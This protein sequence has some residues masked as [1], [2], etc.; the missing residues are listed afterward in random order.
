MQVRLQAHRGTGA[1]SNDPVD[2]CWVERSAPVRGPLSLMELRVNFS[3]LNQFT[4]GRCFF[5]YENAR[6]HS[7]CIEGNVIYSNNTP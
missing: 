4:E 5:H 1:A 7:R 3:F 2:S 6:L